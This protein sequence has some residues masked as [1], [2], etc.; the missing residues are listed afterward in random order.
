[1]AMA[2]THMCA[3]TTV[4]NAQGHLCGITMLVNAHDG[5]WACLTSIILLHNQAGSLSLSNG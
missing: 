1:M 2:N 4:A 3:L 5:K